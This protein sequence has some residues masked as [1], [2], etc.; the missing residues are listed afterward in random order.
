[1]RVPLVVTGANGFV[2]R[3]V[4]AAAVAGGWP[5]RGLVRSE[6]GA[7][8]V[9]EAGGEARILASWSSEALAAALERAAAVVHLANIGAERNGAT[10]EQ[11]NVRGTQAL[12]EAAERAGARRV[13]Y[14]SGLG[15]AR[16]GMAPRCTNRYFLSK[17]AAELALFRS[18]LGV[19]VFR[20]SYVV[21][22]GGELI[23][24]LAREMA[25]GEV[26]RI[27]DGAYR[28]QPIDV[29]DAAAAILASL[30]EGRPAV[31]VFDLVGPEPMSYAAFVERVARVAAG[32]GLGGAYRVREIP[33]VEADRQAA[34]GGYRGLLPDELDCLLC[35]EVADHGPL[36]AL[37]GRP[38]APVD[39]A[40][41]RVLRATLSAA[42]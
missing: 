37:V 14:L 28:M 12:V 4:V 24:G 16:Y 30:D 35:D 11:V 40:I 42:R 22:V 15:V 18:G 31:S 39:A 27:G 13:A 21:G 7:R 20:P 5:V 6:A 9:A 3:H 17:L 10:Y 19:A 41:E 32:L 38:L 2:G 36:E 23:P 1:M 26:E 34:A 8:R 25:A 29:L 33:I